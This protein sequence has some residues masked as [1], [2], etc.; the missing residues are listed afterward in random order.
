MR[1]QLVL[2]VLLSACPGPLPM[3]MDGGLEGSRDG[4]GTCAVAPAFTESLTGCQR[5]ADDYRPREAG[6]A[7]D[8]WPA[9]VSD[10]NVFMPVNPSISSVA[11]AAS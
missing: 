1:V 5:G 2:L 10:S 11:R 4:G 7:N 9:C 3:T 8:T 6:S